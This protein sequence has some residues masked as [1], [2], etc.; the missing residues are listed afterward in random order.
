MPLPTMSARP[1]STGQKVLTDPLPK[2]PTG[3][4]DFPCKTGVRFTSLAGR[5]RKKRLARS[6]KKTVDEKVDTV[7]ENEY[8][9]H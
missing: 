8:H 7:R 5:S 6:P 2:D 4:R 3:W 9:E 1:R